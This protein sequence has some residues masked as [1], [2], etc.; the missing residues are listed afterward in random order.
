MPIQ[1]PALDDR[2]FQDLVDDLLARI[3]AHAPEYQN[4]QV[5]D[6]GRT[7][8][9]LFAW[10]ADTILYRA[11]LI[12]E[13][14]RLSFLRLLGIPLRSATAAR[15]L[16][17]LKLDDEEPF[18]VVLPA[19]TKLSGPVP[20]ESRTPVSVL[21]VTAHAFSKRPLSDDEQKR[22]DPNV[23]A[24]LPEVYGLGG[25]R[26]RYY[27]TTPVFAGGEASAEG[28]DLV[29]DTIDGSLWLALLAANPSKVAD[30]RES[31]G[32]GLDGDAQ[33]INLGVAPAIEIPALFEDVAQRARVPHVWEITTGG[34]ANKPALATLETVADTS[35]GLTRRGVLRLLLPSASSI[36]APPSG[37]AAPFE[38]GVGEGPPRLDDS[39]L[40]ARVVTWLRLRPLSSGAQRVESLKL[41]WIGI[42][43]IEI[44]QRQTGSG[45]VIGTSTGG[46]EQ[47]LWL[48]AENVEPESLRLDVEQDAGFVAWTR[49]DDLALAGRDDAVFTLDPEAGVVRFGDGL[50]GAIPKAGA[51]VRAAAL[52]AGGGRAGNLP[53]KSLTQ[54]REPTDVRGARVTRAIKVE[55]RL[56]TEGGHDRETLA[57]AERRIPALLRHRDRAVTADDFQRVAADTPGVQLGRV[58]VLARFKPQQ[59][60]MDVPG[61]VSVMALPWKSVRQAPNPRADRPLIEA[62]HAY[63]DARRPLGTELYVIGCEYVALALGVGVELHEGYPR[64]ETLLAVRESLRRFLWPLAPGG[65]E[66]AGWPLGRQVRDRELEVVVAQVPGVLEVH[67]VNLFERRQDRWSRVTAV[68]TTGAV[69]LGLEPWAL[70][71]LLAVLV[72]TG[73]PPIDPELLPN[74][75]GDDG[76][77]VPVVPEIC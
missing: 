19:L 6:P 29:R 36:G 74:S 9:E 38:A 77:A 51:R 61:V 40:A 25:K 48:G 64:E 59:R 53:P 11:N 42:N 75:F 45:V 52:R 76:V 69:G 50:R 20:F 46:P 37:L 39:A 33:V 72:A 55:Q 34:G 32:R 54:L 31:L 23:L 26:A 67:G 7:L 21:P 8:I 30:V 70:P 57:E 44:D 2:S 1:P 68:G 63:L 73:D 10:L 49:I 43:A 56:A 17:G 41:S 58:E 5:G 71:E 12:P 60:R 65:S 22:I 18:S 47:A 35:V 16:C 62:V 27:V 24:R 4:I 28:F 15:G 14:Q 66:G 13:R 3:P